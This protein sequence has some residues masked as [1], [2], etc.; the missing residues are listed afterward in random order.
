[1]HLDLHEYNIGDVGFKKVCHALSGSTSAELER[2]DLG[3]NNLTCRDTY[4]IAAFVKDCQGLK[5]LCLENTRLKSKE[6]KLI[7]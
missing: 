2:I 3:G 7:G 1:M 5:V 6:V 4:H